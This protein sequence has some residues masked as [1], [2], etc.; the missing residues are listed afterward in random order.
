MILEAKNLNFLWL[1]DILQFHD[2]LPLWL[3][4][5]KQKHL[6][7]IQLSITLGISWNILLVQNIKKKKLSLFSLIL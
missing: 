1:H 3:K 5:N 2:E 7:F 4:I 6:F